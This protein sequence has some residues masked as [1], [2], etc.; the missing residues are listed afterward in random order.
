MDTTA[1]SRSCI[2]EVGIAVGAIIVVVCLIV[3]V[4]T[5]ILLGLWR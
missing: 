2:G 3:V 4:I 1:R 5:I